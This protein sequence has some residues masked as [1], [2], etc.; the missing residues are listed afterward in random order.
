[1]NYLPLQEPPADEDSVKLRKIFRTIERDARMSG[2]ASLVMELD[3]MPGLLLGPA[4]RVPDGA[5]AAAN[6]SAL[7]CLQRITESIQAGGFPSA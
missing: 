5:A 7:V 6:A 1:M 4:N 3:R 2:N